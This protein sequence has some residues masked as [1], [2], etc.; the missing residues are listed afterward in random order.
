MITDQIVWEEHWH[1]DGHEAVEN[2]NDGDWTGDTDRYVFNRVFHFFRHGRNGV[3]SYIAQ[4]NHGG[5]VENSRRAE[6]E[7]PRGMLR[8]RRRSQILRVSSQEPHHDHERYERD[9]KCGHDHVHLRALPRAAADDDGDREDHDDGDGID[10]VEPAGEG[11]DDEPPFVSR[12][13]EGGSQVSREAPRNGGVRHHVVQHEIRSGEERRK[14]A[15]RDADVA[16]GAAGDGE[17]HGEF[18]VAEGGEESAEAG[19]GVG[20]DDRGA[21]VEVARAAGGDEDAGADHSADSET[22]E[23]VPPES[24]AHVLAG[25]GAD[26]AHL[27]GGG[28]DGDSAAG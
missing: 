8:F 22:N 4:V 3:V 27:V 28:G 17:V 19:D 15:E 7:E 21:G 13:P 10:L 14:L 24:T 25:D 6:R 16:E 23:I 12:D 1:G 18:R 11:R 20:D 2:R 5:S 9:V 26:A